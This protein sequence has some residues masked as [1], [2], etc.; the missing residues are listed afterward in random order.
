MSQLAE[1]YSTALFEL[2]EETNNIKKWQSE[3]KLVRKSL[4][5]DMNKFFLSRQITNNQKKEVLN[6]A[7]SSY[8]DPMLM[9]FINLL[10]DKSRVNYLANILGI[11]NTTCNSYFGIKEGVVFSARNLSDNQINDIEKAMSQKMN[12]NVELINKIDVTLISGIKIEIDNEVIDSSM[13][14]SLDNLKM[15]LLKERR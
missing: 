12:C 8:I 3:A 10:V 11:F 4:D 2:A 13:K 9:N 5:E 14:N 7:F 15:T 6:K 1:R